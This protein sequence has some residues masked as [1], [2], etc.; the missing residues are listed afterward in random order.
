MEFENRHMHI[1]YSETEKFCFATS[2]HQLPAIGVQW[3]EATQ[4]TLR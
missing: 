4:T 2:K 3:L 1:Y